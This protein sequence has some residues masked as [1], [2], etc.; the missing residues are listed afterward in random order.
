[1][2]F[3]N[4]LFNRLS[5][6][7]LR[8]LAK[9][10]SFVKEIGRGRASGRRDIRMVSR[11]KIIL[12]MVFPAF[13]LTSPPSSTLADHR[14]KF[15][16]HEN[17]LTAARNSQ[18]AISLCPNWAS[19]KTPKLKRITHLVDIMGTWVHFFPFHYPYL[20]NPTGNRL[21]GPRNFPEIERRCPGNPERGQNDYPNFQISE[22]GS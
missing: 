21:F 13:P 12:A 10:S 9:F 2:E 5:I 7:R 8:F 14:T 22:D 18:I 1:M 11:K 6:R 19:R 17:R 15:A 3:P 4:P 20:G 16:A